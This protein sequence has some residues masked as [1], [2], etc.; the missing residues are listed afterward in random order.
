MIS[1]FRIDRQH[2]NL[3]LGRAIEI[4]P[5]QFPEFDEETDIAGLEAN[6]PRFTD[7]PASENPGSGSGGQQSGDSDG[8]KSAEMSAESPDEIS[9]EVSEKERAE[10]IEMLKKNEEAQAIIDSAE[11][12]AE[13]IIAAADSEAEEIIKSANAQAEEV[14]KNAEEQ[15]RN[16]GFEA[17]LNEGRLVYE[18]KAKQDDESL[19]NVIA[20]IYNS[21]EDAKIGLEAEVLELS[22]QILRKVVNFSDE[23]EYEPFIPMLKN[24]LKQVR[25][26]GKIYIRVGAEEYE[27]FFSSGSAEIELDGGITVE[28]AV[29]KDVT[30]QPGDLIIDTDAETVNA[31]FTTQL[32]QLELVFKQQLDSNYE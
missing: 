21:L 29:I 9:D 32:K 2:V 8:E 30:M 25:I 19:K 17:G 16:E 4:Q 20:E 12:E 6:L 14:F 26:G 13:Q 22:T 24:A 28:A 18:E 23:T 11:H 5:V 27:R 3:S 31:G 10:I 7:A 15:G 1:L